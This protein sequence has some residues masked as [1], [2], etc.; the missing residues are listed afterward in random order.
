MDEDTIKQLFIKALNILGKERNLIIAGFEE[1]RDS[2]FSTEALEADVHVLAS[3]MNTVAELIQKCIDENARIAQDQTEYEKRYDSLVQRFDAAKEKLD[4]VQAAITKK[5]AQRQM[6]ENFMEA[7][8]SLP[9]QVEIFDEG[10]W[11]ALCEC[12]TVYGKDDIRVTFRNGMEI[13]L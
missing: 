11:Y 5:Q 12:I 10:T 4:E 9:E 13:P 2:A 8:Q 7:L 3:E 1:I 6:M